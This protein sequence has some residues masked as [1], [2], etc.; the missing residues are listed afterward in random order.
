MKGAYYYPERNQMFGRKKKE[1]KL[2]AGPKLSDAVASA[3]KDALVSETLSGIRKVVTDHLNQKQ[4]KDYS[5][6]RLYGLPI[7]PI[8]KARLD[9][10]EES[11]T[12]TKE[13]S[14]RAGVP[15]AVSFD[16]EMDGMRRAYTKLT[17]PDQKADE[18]L[19][20]LQ[21]GKSFEESAAQVRKGLAE[22]DRKR[23]ERKKK[24][25]DPND[26]LIS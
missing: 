5:Y 23:A 12:K 25:P 20:D 14:S 26:D 13:Y 18:I 21:H 24:Y 4:F 7:D 22:L 8:A 6:N 1:P 11:S 3:Q 10:Y 2:P 16:A 9:R 17:P 19:L 15:M